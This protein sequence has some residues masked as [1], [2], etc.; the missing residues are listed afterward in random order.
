MIANLSG[1]PKR[2]AQGSIGTSN[3]TLYT[4]VPDGKSAILDIMVVNTTSAP[5]NLTMYVGSASAANVFGWYLSSIP[6]YSSMQYSG[7][8]VLN[9]NEALIAVGSANGLTTSI[10]GLERV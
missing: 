8:Q 10:S 2:L 4:A 7:F 9:Q 1:T 3:T 5:I 6:A